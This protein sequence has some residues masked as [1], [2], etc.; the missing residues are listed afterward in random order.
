MRGRLCAAH[1]LR[2]VKLIGE[3]TRG[4]A[5]SPTGSVPS[6]AGK[7]LSGLAATHDQDATT[8]GHEGRGDAAEEKTVGTGL[9]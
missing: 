9:G 3:T 6:H 4:G 1:R 8:D 5:V 7:M 2:V